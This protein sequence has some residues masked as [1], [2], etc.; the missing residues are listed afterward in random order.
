MTDRS[1]SNVTEAA[2]SLASTSDSNRNASIDEQAHQSSR[3]AE[4]SDLATSQDTASVSHSSNAPASIND[5]DSQPRPSCDSSRRDQTDQSSVR[6]ITPSQPALKLFPNVAPPRKSSMAARRASAVPRY[7]VI[8]NVTESPTS[9]SQCQSV[10]A[11]N[12]NECSIPPRKS[13]DIVTDTRP[14]E[15][16][17]N[18][19]GTSTPSAAPAAEASTEEAPKESSSPGQVKARPT[20]LS[21]GTLKAFPLPA[22]TRP[23]PSLPELERSPSAPP[24][25]GAPSLR[26]VRSEPTSSTLQS[27]SAAVQEKQGT[28]LAID[29]PRAVDSRPA[30]AL[31]SVDAEGSMT[32]DEE[33]LF[34]PSLSDY[35]KSTSGLATPR[36]RA[37]S[38]R[39]PRM[40]Q[41][42]ETPGQDKGQPLAD[43]P[44]LGHAIPTKNSGKRAVTGL[45]INSQV[46][47]NSLPFGLPSP[48]PTASLPSAPPPR[49]SPPAPPGRQVGQRNATAPHAKLSM[50]SS[51]VPA[52]PGSYRNSMVSRSDSSRSSLR[53][54]SFPDSYEESRVESRNE[55]PLPSSDDEVFGPREDSKPSHREP[56]NQKRA[57]TVRREYETANGSLTSS[58]SRLRSPQP[59]RSMM[60]QSRSNHDLEKTSSPQSQYSLSSHQLR[61][62][63]NSH[64]S[65]APPR[66]HYLEDRVANLERQ[67]QMLQAALMAALNA[68]GKN[69]LDGLNLDS[70]M[71][72]SFP[73]APY[74]NQYPGRQYPRPD[75]WVGSSRS[76]E[77]S[78]FETSSSYKDS[79]ANVKHLD[80]MIED[81]ESGWMSDKSSLSGARVA[82]QR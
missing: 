42:P 22:P 29:S 49:H 79:R 30:T 60:P 44:V 48:P 10:P 74:S 70:N 45:Q 57:Q 32:D 80:N 16:G 77:H 12:T 3:S 38:V 6:N 25:T 19:S 56:H 34:A 28:E 53:N 40:Q 13:S 5:T 39:I 55:S 27:S 8:T 9:S 35:S 68:S 37:S 20:S 81:I 7:Q 33:S 62:S 23:L 1:P 17:P 59:T 64:R 67:N 43:S 73:H 31:E 58:R 14:V 63:E 61:E 76:S 41:L 69:P 15:S 18:I 65:R 78:G 66:D 72:P 24:S 50:K 54:E 46:G 11:D 75:S 52:G 36:G 21:M 26:S 51:D 2:L 47:R 82:R 4:S 71:T